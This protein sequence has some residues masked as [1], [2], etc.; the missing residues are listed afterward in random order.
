MHNVPRT[1]FEYG[2]RIFEKKDKNTELLSVRSSFSLIPV[3]N[4]WIKI[5]CTGYIWRNIRTNSYFLILDDFQAL[6]SR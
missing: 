1:S 6:N 4:F 2:V 3:P 5:K